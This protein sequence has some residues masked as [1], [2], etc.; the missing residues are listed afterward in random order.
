M[1]QAY[2]SKFTSIN[3]MPRI[4]GLIEKCILDPWVGIYDVL[5]YGGGRFDKLTLALADRSIQNWIYDPYNRSEN[6]NSA[7][8]YVLEGTPADMGICSNVLNV[9][10]EK[11][12]RQEILQ[13]I[14]RLVKPGA[15]FFFTVYEGDRSGIGKKVP[16]KFKAGSI[17]WQ[18]NRKT[19]DYLDEIQVVFAHVDI[20]QGG[21][22][23]LLRAVA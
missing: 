14:K 5:D 17:S 1:K 18:E 6:H 23:R 19:L 15:N 22:R 3:K 16:R 7:V 11:A 21:G 10:R 9:I 2:D 12:V 20:P 13:D 8:R 4:L